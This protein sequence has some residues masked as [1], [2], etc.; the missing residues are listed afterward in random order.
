M[1]KAE[2]REETI[3]RFMNKLDLTREEA[4][5][6]F[7][8]DNSTSVLPEVKA[9]EEKAKECKRRY[10]HKFEL[11]KPVKRERKV[12]EDKKELLTIIEQ[13]ISNVCSIEEIVNETE[14]KFSYNGNSYSIKM[15]KH[16]NK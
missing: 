12:D 5:Q 8:D 1:T 16:R 11:R 4:E 15:T 3:V 6:L 2:K 7:E 10:E 14:I 9:I 13:A